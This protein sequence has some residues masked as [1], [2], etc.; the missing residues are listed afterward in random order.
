MTNS[1]GAN[2][3]NYAIRT[4]DGRVLAYGPSGGDDS[5]I[6]PPPK[7]VIAYPPSVRPQQ[8]SIGQVEQDQ[9]RYYINA[10]IERNNLLYDQVTAPQKWVI[11]LVPVPNR[12]VFTIQTEDGQL[13]VAPPDGQEG[14]VRVE[15]ILYRDPPKYPDNVLF[16]LTPLY[17]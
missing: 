7:P 5:T 8:F 13:W 10:L 4:F 3:A 6:P 12:V 16:E 11:T 17:N 2:I 14:Q 9:N 1:P 15:R